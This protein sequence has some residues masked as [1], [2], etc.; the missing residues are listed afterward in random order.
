MLLVGRNP[1]SQDFIVTNGIMVFAAAIA[2]VSFDRVNNAVLNTLND[3]RMVGL[4]VLRSGTA[5][6]IP[7]EED[8]HARSRFDI[9]IYPLT[10]ILEPLNAIDTACVLRNDAGFD[11]SKMRGSL[12]LI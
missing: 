2:R 6:I 7:I 4:S 9:V 10:T 1:V 11:I 12:S 3:A 8:N 5:F